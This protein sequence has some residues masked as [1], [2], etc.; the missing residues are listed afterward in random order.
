MGVV[1]EPRLVG[2]SASEGHPYDTPGCPVAEPQVV[3]YVPGA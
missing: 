2:G 3:R 1:D